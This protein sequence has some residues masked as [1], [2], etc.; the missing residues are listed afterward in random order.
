MK[1]QA[2]RYSQYIRPATIVLDFVVLLAFAEKLLS[3]EVKCLSAFF[4]LLFF[5]VVIALYTKFYRVYRFTKQMQIT[6]KAFKQHVL[7]SLVTLAI[8]GIYHIFA[9]LEVLKYTTISIV[10]IVFI[11]FAMFLGL[12]FLR[13]NFDINQRSILVVGT[14]E[15][16]KQ[17][18]ERVVDDKSYGYRLLHHFDVK[19]S[20]IYEIFD[21]AKE[22]K[23]EEIYLG[24]EHI[25]TD[26]LYQF[27]DFS[28]NNLI[29]LK[30]LPSQ[31]DRLSSNLKVD[32]FDMIPVINSRSTPLDD[33]LNY[34]IKRLFDIV[35]STLVIVFLLSWIVPLIGILIKLE[36]KG[37]V[38]FKQK[39]HGLGL[40]EFDCYKFRSMIVN[41]DAN[42]KAATKNDSRV[43][44]IGAFIRKTNIDELPQFFNVFL[45][46]MSV[47]GPR[48]HM[49]S[50]IE[51]YKEI[52]RYKTRHFI[53]PGITGM[54][55]T[56]G[57]RGEI[58]TDQDIINRVKY[59]LY[60]M[61]NWS[62]LLDVKIICLTV[63]NMI[64]GEQKA[65]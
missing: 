1:R 54:A 30:F 19:E 22:S 60:Y 53:K 27:V 64:K 56:H 40:E 61:E 15:L 52:D 63:I 62:F 38:F 29:V 55:Q 5:W 7:F 20:T 11:K 24:L 57:C 58:E 8:N 18:I 42:K 9:P 12:R 26:E 37:P 2:R 44:K 65:Y 36:S 6:Q 25:S 14:D 35:F 50:F 43:T 39:R 49:V 45:G 51:K 33:P 34:F 48:P 41:K 17:F 23:V 10:V 46:E 16:T 4:Y 13:K 3:T 31:K 28:D 32:Y 59:D 21:F 47:V